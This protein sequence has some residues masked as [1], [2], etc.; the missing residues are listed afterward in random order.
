M[1]GRPVRELLR[2]SAPL[3]AVAAVLVLA[4]PATGAGPQPDRAPPTPA[5]LAPDPLPGTVVPGTSSTAPASRPRVTTPASRRPTYV[6]PTSTPASTSKR[7]TAVH[8]MAKHPVVRHPV[9]TPVR[10]RP[11]RFLLPGIALPALIAADPVRAPRD[12]DA[13]LAGLALLI[14]AATAASGARLV[15]VWNRR[16]R[17]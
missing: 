5:T 17:V 16:A 4:P 10:S 1:R 14:A 9:P 3:V 12:L 8:A 6:A 2:Q 7:P 15:T 13:V 11:T